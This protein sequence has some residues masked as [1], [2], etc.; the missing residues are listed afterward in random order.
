MVMLGV[1]AGAAL[2]LAMVGLY[3]IMAYVTSQRTREIGIRMALG[4]QRSDMLAL[5]LRQSFGLVLVGVVL[6]VLG[7]L[8]GSH[9][10]GSLLYGVSAIDFPTYLLVVALL[11][12]AAFIASLIPAR[13]A[14][15]VNPTEALRAE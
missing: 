15:K 13:R 4:A 1:F 9:L 3:G 12:A 11:G 5:V 8:G 2:L 10:L 7:A 14:T 6:G